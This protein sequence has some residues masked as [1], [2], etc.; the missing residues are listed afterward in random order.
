MLATPTSGPADMVQGAALLAAL[1][2]AAGGT[3]AMSMSPA[4]PAPSAPRIIA[5]LGDSLSVSPSRQS[6]FPTVLQ[7]RLEK[8]HDGW[9][10]LNFG[11]NGDVTAQGLARLPE[12]MARKPEILVLALGA[13]DG[14]RGVPVDVVA[15]N[16]ETIVERARGGGARVLLCGMEA[17]PI[18]GWRY[19]LEF[20]RL[21]PALA[22]KYDLPLVP[23][24]LVGVLGDPD[25]NR[26]DR[27][28]PNAKGAER[29]ADTI[30]PVLERMLDEAVPAAPGR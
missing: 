23:F 1:L 18:G 15:R 13:N 16:L 30:W 6:S 28:H 26:E 21:Y 9:E 11:R 17:P 7:R 27:V 12:V 8:R 29:I 4:N 24:L 22:A 5:V 14:L 25:L 10:V 3:H 2:C 19:S 20:H